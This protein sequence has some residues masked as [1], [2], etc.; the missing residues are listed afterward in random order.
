MVYNIMSLQWWY[1]VYTYLNDKF[2]FGSVSI[3]GYM[4][5]KKKKK[6]HMWLY[7]ESRKKKKINKKRIK[8]QK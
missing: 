5:K 3:R 1:F 8:E 7:N 4:K 2:R 6:P